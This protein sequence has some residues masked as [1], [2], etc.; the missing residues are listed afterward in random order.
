[1]VTVAVLI[2]SCLMVNLAATAEPPATYF[3]TIYFLNRT[4]QVLG[5]T[6]GEMS[7]ARW[8]GQTFNID[9]FTLCPMMLSSARV[10]LAVGVAI[11]NI[12]WQLDRKYTCNNQKGCK[13]LLIEVTEAKNRKYIFTI[14]PDA[15][16]AVILRE[17]ETYKSAREELRTAEA[18][19]PG[20]EIAEGRRLSEAA[21]PAAG[22]ALGA[23]AIP[24]AVTPAIEGSV[25]EKEEEDY[26]FVSTDDSDGFLR[27]V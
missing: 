22:A 7:T 5:F 12:A 17:I 4:G 27:V 14:F 1:M 9:P 11:K 21:V 20:T 19:G 18:A 15:D 13:H 16:I 8:G 24:L 10:E 6:G 23:G 25:E 26:V 2:A 3:F